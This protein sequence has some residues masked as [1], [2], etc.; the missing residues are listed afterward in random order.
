MAFEDQGKG[1]IRVLSP[2]LLTTVQ[3]AGRVG[4][5]KYGFGT[6]GALDL[7]ALAAA[8]LLVGNAP[9]EAALECTL[10][11]PTLEFLCDATVAVTG[12]NMGAALGGGA[13]PMYAAFDVKRGDILKLGFAASGCRAVIAFAGGIG[14]PAVMGGKSTSLCCGVGG[15]EGRALRAGDL[16]PLAAPRTGLPGLAARR[17]APPENPADGRERPVVL[18]AVPG[19][20]DDYFTEEGLAAFFSGEYAVTGKSDRMGC[21]LEGPEIAAKAGVDIISDGIPLGAVQVPS[22]GRPIVMLADRQTAGGYAKIATVISADLPKLAQCRAGDRIRFE[23]VSVGEAQALARAQREALEALA[24]RLARL[25]S[26]DRP[27]A[28][29]IAALLRARAAAAGTGREG[30][31]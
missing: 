7:P 23:K 22:S 26:G 11:G 25:E 15:F 14:V 12:C 2:G 9:G 5:L 3:D 19:P 18:R 27:A 6:S 21:R 31:A 10:T 1:E 16:L 30:T 24:A 4:Y 20:Q 29:R 8:N 13:A 17:A 28:R